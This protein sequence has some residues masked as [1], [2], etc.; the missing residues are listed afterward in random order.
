MYVFCRDADGAYFFQI[1]GRVMAESAALVPVP[2][3]AP[4]RIDVPIDFPYGG[5]RKRQ[6][7]GQ[8]QPR[9]IATEPQAGPIY[10]RSARVW[11]DNHLGTLVDIYV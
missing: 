7:T 4:A 5:T 2:F 1:G 10:T 8:A 9:S 3:Y 6:R 11:T